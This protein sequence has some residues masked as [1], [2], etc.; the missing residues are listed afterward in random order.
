[1]AKR[2][3]RYALAVVV[4]TFV[5]AGV[6]G[7]WGVREVL[8]YPERHH[9]G[10]G[11]TV[12]LTVAKGMKLPDV[13][14]LLEQNGLI[15]RPTWFRFYAMHR[16]LAN[17]VR[18]GT[19][20]LRD[21]LPPREILDL[22]VKGVDEIDVAVTIPEGKHIREVFALISAAGIASA[23]DL[24]AV[25]RDAEWLKQQGIEGETV[26]GYL[27]PDT[28]RFRKPSPPRQVL[29]TMVKKHRIVYDELRAK[30]QKSLDKIKK[31]LD[32]SDRD[33]VVM[34][35]IVEKETGDPAERAR[36][37]SVFLNRLTSPS[38]T[39]RR[40]ETD[41][42]I[43]YGCTI[44]V[45]K[46]AACQIWNPAERLRR[47]QLDDAE[48]RYNTYQHAGLPPG[49]IS[50]PGRASLEATMAPESTQ[51]LYFVAK[52]ANGKGTHVFS[53]TYEEHARWV[54]KY[55]K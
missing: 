45:E 14:K 19:Y 1:M 50:N 32:W 48:N 23:V 25:G 3:F 10:T 41:P 40:L 26:E 24:E 35:S 47:A 36:V 39:S 42:T 22:L 21:D 51:Y 9:R 44:P 49:P 2:A 33:V 11:N 46:S 53:R 17:K 16:G 55:Q 28:Y 12:S 43:R 20:E 29:E 31:Q 27:F 7:G 8:R 6:A 34:A 37:A 18:A 54:E 5:A 13:A 38:F 15:D 30:H 4:A 52:D